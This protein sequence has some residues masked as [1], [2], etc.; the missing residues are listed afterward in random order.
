MS[1]DAVFRHITLIDNNKLIADLKYLEAL[2]IEC[3]KIESSDDKYAS[4]Y[5]FERLDIYGHKAFDLLIDNDDNIAG[6]C[7][8]YNGGRYPEGVFRIMNRLYIRPDCRSN[9]FS[10]ITRALYENQ[11]KRHEDSIKMLFLSRNEKK[12]RLHVMKWARDCGE[13]GWSVS[14]NLIKVANCE[15]RACYQYIAYKKIYD[16]DWPNK[17]LTYEEWMS[18]EE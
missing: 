12:G 17:E 13:K 11:R 18:L 14:D 9:Y 8:L 10:P 7:G 16:V 1:N 15:K 6:W 4:N 3:K 2:K 5:S